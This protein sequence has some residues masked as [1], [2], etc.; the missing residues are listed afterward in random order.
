MDLRD[1]NRVFGKT[2][3]LG[4]LSVKRVKTKFLEEMK[5]EN[6]SKFFTC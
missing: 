2:D 1:P 5:T 4:F 3:D 6:F